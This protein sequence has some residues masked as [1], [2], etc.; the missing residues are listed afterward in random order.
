MDTRLRILIRQYTLS[1]DS[2]TAVRVAEE[3]LRSGAGGEVILY[4]VEYEALE[5]FRMDEKYS[6]GIYLT[7]MEA[8]E[9]AKTCIIEMLNDYDADYE[10][11]FNRP[12]ESK[13]PSWSL[14]IRELVAQNK[15]K[16][17][18]ELFERTYQQ[19]FRINERKL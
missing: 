6:C 19:T 4:E 5:S 10:F 18:R 17:A 13:P 16:E 9:A 7:L 3:L 14:K 2:E 1:R 15:N 11:D 12:S 8:E